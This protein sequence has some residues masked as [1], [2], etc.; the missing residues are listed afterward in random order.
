MNPLSNIRVLD[1]TRILSG[2]FCTMKLGDM[3]AE[4]IKIEQPG[5]GDDT[6]RWGPPFIKGRRLP[7]GLSSHRVVDDSS[8]ESAYFLSV[9]RNKKSLTLDLKSKEGKEILKRLIRR[10]DVMVENF[11]VGV[12]EKLGFGYRRV[13]RMNPRIIYCSISGYG[14]TS[15]RSHVPSYDLIVQGESGLMDLT[16]FPDGPPTKVGISLADVAAGTLAFEGILLALLQRQKTGKGQCVDI[17]L[18]DSLLSLFAYQSQIALSSDQ[19]AVRK[20]NRHPT[21]TPYETYRT[22]D[23]YINVAVGSEGLWTSFCKA[24]E[25]QGLLTDRRFA[26]N[27]R[28]V[29]NRQA[30]ERVLEPVMEKKSSAAWIRI[31]SA[32]GIP[33]GR[34]NS[35]KDALRTQVVRERGMIA[36]IRHR[37]LGMLP[38]VGNPIKLSLYRTACFQAPPL[39][40]EHTNAVLRSLGYTAAQ[41]AGLRQKGVV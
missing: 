15:S 38:M 2:P 41:I 23:G 30:L 24:I 29:E 18:L 33:V 34:I 5:T 32:A 7:T 28:R 39:L 20:G 35:V 4:I 6:R 26:T 21:I 10:S 36:N 12:M 17:S 31:L 27:S 16:G 40:G 3:G 11:R 1:L 13:R 19:P 8:S 14:Q 25:R 37:T 9:N 22:K